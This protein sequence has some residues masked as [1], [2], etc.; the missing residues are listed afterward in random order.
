M[1]K[2]SRRKPAKAAPKREPNP[3]DRVVEMLE[4]YEEGTP[5]V[6]PMACGDCPSDEDARHEDQA[7]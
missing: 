3:L 2:Q 4:E 6:P 1:P 5:A 7:R